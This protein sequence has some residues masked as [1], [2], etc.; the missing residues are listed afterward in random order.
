LNFIDIH[1][2]ILPGLDDGP[3]TLEESVEM[4]EMAKEDGIS[5]IFA[6]PHI[7][8]GLYPNKGPEII[9]RVEDLRKHLPGGLKLF[10]GADVRVVPDLIRRRE[11]GDIL[12]LDG[13]GYMLLELPEYVVPPH[14][15]SFIFNLRHKGITPII[16]HPERHFRLMYDSAGLR[17]FRDRGALCQITAMSITGGFGREVMRAS[18]SMIEQGLTD[19]VASD[20]HNAGTRPPILSK[21][22]QEV[23]RHFGDG[24]A[25]LLFFRNPGRIMENVRRKS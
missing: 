1:C 20:A 11:S 17:G 16:T 18:F 14:L 13:S 9:P 19:I 3:A 6:T 24:T 10:C 22:Y 23:K 12:E 8:D 25:E 2:H 4:L 5:H 21:A 7:L 15:D